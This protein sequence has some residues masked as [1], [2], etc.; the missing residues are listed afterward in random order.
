MLMEYISVRVTNEEETFNSS[1]AIKTKQV[2][3]KNNSNISL[4]KQRELTG[5]DE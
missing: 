3:N 5:G 4:V 1:F 2:K